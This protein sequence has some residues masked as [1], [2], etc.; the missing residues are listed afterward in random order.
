MLFLYNFI[1]KKIKQEYKCGRIS[2]PELFFSFNMRE[3]TRAA[4]SYGSTS[5]ASCL[6]L[7]TDFLLLMTE[8]TDHDGLKRT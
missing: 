3:T 7:E 1:I 6:Y 4:V 8:S 2:G 5:T